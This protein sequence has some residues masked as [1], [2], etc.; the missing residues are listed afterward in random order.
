M[1]GV[2]QEIGHLTCWS[3]PNGYDSHI[4]GTLEMRQYEPCKYLLME[5]TGGKLTR[6]LCVKDMGCALKAQLYSLECDME[7]SWSL[8][9]DPVTVYSY[10]E[11]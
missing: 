1:K 6:Q 2:T 5:G 7:A 9:A 4:W 11:K 8:G 10:G 3:E